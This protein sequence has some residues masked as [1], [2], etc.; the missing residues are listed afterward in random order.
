MRKSICLV[1]MLSSV[2]SIPAFGQWQKIDTVTNGNYYDHSPQVDHGGIGGSFGWVIFARDQGDG[3]SIVAIR[4]WSDREVWDSS[5]TIISPASS[6]TEQQSPD[7][8]SFAR[9]EEGNYVTTT[10]AAWQRKVNGIWNIWYSV[11]DNAG[12]GWSMPQPLTSDS[13]NNTNP[14]IRYFSF[15]SPIV[16]WKRS[17]NVMYSIFDGTNLTK[18][19]IL[20]VSNF[21]SVEYDLSTFKEVAWTTMDSVTKER[22]LAM[23]EITSAQPVSV[24]LGDTIRYGGDI[25]D[26]TSM[27]T[28]NGRFFTF[29]VERYGVSW[30]YSLSWLG[31]SDFW[32]IGNIPTENDYSTSTVHSSFFQGGWSDSG[33]WMWE[34]QTAGE[35]SIV[36]VGNDSIDTFVGGRNPSMG[37]LFLNDTLAPK[38]SLGSTANIAVWE[39]VSGEYSHIYGRAFLFSTIDLGVR[40]QNAI[41]GFN[42][43]QNYPNPFNPSTVISYRLPVV[44][45]VTLKIYDVLGREVVTLVDERKSPGTYEVK[46]DGSRFASGVY[47]CRMNAG[48]YISTRKIM[49]IK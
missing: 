38:T 13:L 28:P 19:G 49:L 31:L 33:H 48:S 10:L 1:V 45:H 15:S 30:S 22:S 24:S 6:D 8:C 16:L 23:G 35:T 37:L 34:R 21:D 36:F 40:Q 29:D 9:Y 42:L 26:I 20:L 43:S 3:N 7:V 32:S 17:G 44:S 46:F 39:S 14:K 4:Y 5:V 2:L 27:F 47:F 41:M 12:D 11:T 25:S 18:P